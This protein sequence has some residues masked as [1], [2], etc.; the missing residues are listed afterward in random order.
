MKVHGEQWGF[1]LQDYFRHR[2]LGWVLI[3]GKREKWQNLDVPCYAY[4]WGIA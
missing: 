3:Q 2:K 1:H 4:E